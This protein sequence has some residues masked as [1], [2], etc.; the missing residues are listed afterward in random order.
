MLS[1]WLHCGKKNASENKTAEVFQGYFV[2]IPR[3]E[4]PKEHPMAVVARAT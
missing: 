2:S 1:R 3:C 4:A